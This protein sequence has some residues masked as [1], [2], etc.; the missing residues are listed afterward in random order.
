MPK[1]E[2]CR[3]HLDYAANEVACHLEREG[4]HLGGVFVFYWGNVT[5]EEEDALSCYFAAHPTMTKERA[6]AEI[7]EY[8]D[9]MEGGDVTKTLNPIKKDLQ[10]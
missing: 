10:S 7:R 1:C 2:R 3:G 4:M 9:K 8:L 5:G 6:I